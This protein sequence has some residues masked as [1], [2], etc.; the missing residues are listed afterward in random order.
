MSY[1]DDTDFREVACCSR[2]KWTRTWQTQDGF[3]RSGQANAV[4]V[5]S[6]GW[7]QVRERDWC[8]VVTAHEGSATAYTWR[9]QHFTLGSALQPAKVRRAAVSAAQCLPAL[10]KL[11]QALG[12]L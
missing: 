8:N 10:L 1:L 11:C 3:R 6:P 4:G 9:L 2:V 7:P 12:M 5:T